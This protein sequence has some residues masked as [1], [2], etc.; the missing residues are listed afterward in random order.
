MDAFINIFQ[1][2]QAYGDRSISTN[3]VLRNVDWSRNIQGMSVVDAQ[4]QAFTLDPGATKLVFDGTRTT[5]IG[6]A[7]AFD[8]SLSPLDPSIYR[9]TWSGTNPTL[10]TDRAMALTGRTLTFTVLANNSVELVVSGAGTNDFTGVLPG[11]T[12]FIPNTNTG[13]SSSPVSV[14]NSGFW[15]VLSVLSS[16]KLSLSR[17][18]GKDFEAVGEAVVLS[19][20]DQLQAFST[21]GVQVGDK[22]D[23]TSGFATAT[24][25]TFTV[26]TVTSKFFEVVSTSALPAQTGIAPT[27]TGMVFYTDAKSVLYIEADQSLFV[28][29]N[30]STDGS[31]RIDPFESANPDRVG[32]YFKRGAAWSLTLVNRSTVTSN[33]L[34][35]SAE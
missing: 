3:P 21:T 8:V 26:E 5:T 11:D 20:N 7:T 27:A 14:L 28:R 29:L 22:V 35:I 32:T 10:R 4:A 25:Q 1:K 34:V 2:I 16:T 19:S 6:P 17:F 13:D 33:V 31:Q 24:Q 23:I 30:G 15:L 12:V 18:P 9:F